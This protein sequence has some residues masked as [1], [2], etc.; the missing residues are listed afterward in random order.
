MTIKWRKSSFSAEADGNAC[1]ELA[2]YGG[3][4]LIRESDEPGSV[5][6]AAPA[7]L[8]AFLAG[9]KAGEFDGVM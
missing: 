2:S 7:Q 1:L 3:V 6:E 5:I 4:V 8:R 9:M